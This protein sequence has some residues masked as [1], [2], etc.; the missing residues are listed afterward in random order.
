MESSLQK[1]FFSVHGC[2]AITGLQADG[3]HTSTEADDVRLVGG[4][5]RCAGTLE[6]K[7]QG[8]WRPMR[9]YNWTLKAAAVVCRELHCG[10]PVSVGEREDSSDRPVWWIRSVC[11]QSGSALRK[12]VT[13][14]YS[15]SI[16]D[17][18][19]SGPTGLLIILVVR[20]LTLL[21]LLVLVNAAL[22]FY[23]KA[24]RGQKPGRQEDIELDYYNL[25][26]CAAE[27]GPTEEEGAQGAE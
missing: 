19:C 20:P 26:V 8:D 10:S 12:C 6:L 14:Y 17:L 9:Y 18:T 7:Y 1:C 24:S 25:G 21:L 16:L 27:G 15:S 3:Q 13:S 2:A 11:V 22:Y 4:A 23:Y 5:S